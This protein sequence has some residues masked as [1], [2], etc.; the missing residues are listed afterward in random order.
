MTKRS[1]GDGS[2]V[3]RGKNSFRLRYR[4]GKQRF[5]VTFHGTPAEARAELRRLLRG[6]D[7]GEHVA[8]D[9]G[10][11]AGWARAWID[12]GCPG[13]N[14]TAVGNRSI[15]RY[16]E[17]LRLHVLPTLGDYKL[18]EIHSTDID[19][20]YVALEGKL[21]TRTAQQ[22]HS[23]FNAFLSAAVRT[24]KL[25][26]NPMTSI[27]KVPRPGEPDHGA[28][29]DDQQ[30]RQLV[31]GFKGSSLFGIVSVAAFTGMR[32]NEILALR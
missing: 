12:I 25:A 23:V 19:R 2:I 28:V 22:V 15:E 6:G 32:R 3:K 16:S 8:P 9:K 29:L 18:Q 17:I 31:Q 14:R 11:L 5:G 20:L 27:T 24:K 1:Y 26:V 4:I 10:T 30:L 13:R 7:T 21:H